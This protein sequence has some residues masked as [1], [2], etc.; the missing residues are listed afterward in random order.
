MQE[1]LKMKAGGSAGGKRERKC[2]KLEIDDELLS[3]DFK[4]V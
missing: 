1:M 2:V 3:T 4:W